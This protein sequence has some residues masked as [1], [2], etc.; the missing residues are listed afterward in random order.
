[1]LVLFFF[2]FFFQAEDGIRD[3]K[4]T[5]VQTCALPIY[6][7]AS[8]AHSKSGRTRTRIDGEYRALG[9]RESAETVRKRQLRW[10]EQNR[11][12]WRLNRAKQKARYY[13]QFQKNTRQKGR[14][15]TPVEDA[16][17]TAKDRPTDDRKLS[18]ALGRSVQAIQQRRYLLLRD[19]KDRTV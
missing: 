15:W 4:V 5:G 14:R 12:A 2:F 10:R 19:S 3:Y 16:R 8:A 9:G 11:K 7:K 13:Q 17:L 1:M 18:K 6:E